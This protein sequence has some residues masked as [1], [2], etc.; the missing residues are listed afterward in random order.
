MAYYN[1]TSN[2]VTSSSAQEACEAREGRCVKTV[3]AGI[4]LGFLVALLTL[5]IGVIL[6]AYFST[7]FLSS[8]A[9][10]IV[11][12]VVLLVL[13]AVILIYAGCIASKRCRCR[14]DNCC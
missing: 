4:V 3:C 10:I 9:A 5:T 13:I 7:T 14:R 12:A 11:F 2:A 1:T 6:G 8:I